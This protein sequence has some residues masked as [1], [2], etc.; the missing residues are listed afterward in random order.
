MMF[1]FQ[2]VFYQILCL[3]I[4]YALIYMFNNSYYDTRGLTFEECRKIDQK[5][6]YIYF[7]VNIV[8]LMYLSW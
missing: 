8:F 3:I 7:V 1:M 5:S 2:V 4:T 6:L